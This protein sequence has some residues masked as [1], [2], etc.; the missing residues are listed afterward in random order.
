MTLYNLHCERCGGVKAH[1]TLFG[2]EYV[3]TR[4]HPEYGNEVYCRSCE[5]GRSKADLDDE[6]EVWATARVEQGVA[7]TIYQD[8]IRDDE[9]LEQHVERVVK[10]KYLGQIAAEI[11]DGL[12]DSDVSSVGFRREDGELDD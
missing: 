8:S 6:V 11:A 7:L 2:N 12:S 9:T 3:Q 5:R 1:M 10:E 4:K